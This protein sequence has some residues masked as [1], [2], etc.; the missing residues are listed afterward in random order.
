[1]FSP[2]QSLLPHALAALC[3]L[4]ILAPALSQ[5][6]T[7]NYKTPTFTL[8]YATQKPQIDGTIAEAEWR[9]ALGINA[10]QTSQ[11]TLSPR[12]AQWWLSWDEDNLYLA[13]RSPL[14]AGERLIQAQRRRDKDY[15]VVFDD[16]YEI[17]LDAQTHSPDGQP[18]FFQFLS[19]FAGARWDVMHEPAVGNFRMGWSSDWQ[20]RSR[21]NARN[22]WEMEVAIPR[23]SIYHDAPFRDGEVLRGLLARNFKRPWEQNTVEGAG[24]FAV[25]DTYSQ[26]RL[27]KS[28]PAL[29][30]LGVGDSDAQTVG[31]KLDAY[32]PGTAAP[33]R[34][35]FQS[36][37]GVKREGI[38]TPGETVNEL[39]LDKAGEAGNFRIRVMQGQTTL[40]DWA[41][42]RKFGDLQIPKQT[43]DDRGDTVKLLLSLNPIRDYVRVSGDFIDYDAR[44]QIATNRV[45][46]KDAQGV[47]LA[48]QDLPLDKLSYVSG[49]LKLPTLAPGQYS[50]TLTALGADGK[51][52]LTREQK[53]EKKDPRSF[54]WWNTPDGNIERVL[55]PWTP[56]KF[57][58]D[59]FDVWGR[60]MRAGHAGLPS[61]VVTQMN[62]LLA[63]PIHLVAQTADGQTLVSRPAP[64][65]A[66]SLRD[67]RAVAQAQ[68][69]LGEIQITTRVTVEFDGMYKVEMK[70]DP[71]AAVK[72]RSLRLVVPLKNASA[73]YL[74][75][76]GEGI[77]SGY[78]YG[79][80]P[81]EKQGRLWDS[82]QV[83]SQPMA[84]GS[85]IP[86]VWIG[87]PKGGLAW[88]ANSDQGW[89][90]NDQTPALEVRRDTPQST[91]LMLNLV[92][93]DFTLDAPRTVTFAFQA[94]PVKPMHEGWRMDSWWTGDTFRDY[95]QVEPKGGNL[96]FSSIPFTL[97]ADKSRAMVEAQ[98]AGNTA[99]LLGVDK[100]RGNA[101]PYFEHIRIGEKFVPEM[102]YF[103]DEWKTDV[104]EGLFY[105]KSY[106]DYMIYN[107]ARW[108]EQTGIDGFYVDNMHPLAD[109]N[110]EAGR[111]YVLPNGKV[112]PEYA[113]FETRDYFLRLRAVFA[114]HGKR[115]KIVLHM[116][117]NMIVPWVGAADIALDGEDNVIYPQMNK[118]FM[119][120]WSLERLR[121]DYPAQW[122][123]AVNFLQE[124]QGNWEGARLAKAMRAYSGSLILHDVLASANANGLNTP[125]WIGR[126][127]FGIENPDTKF[128][129]YWEENKGFDSATPDV[130]VSGWKRP[131]K[132]LLAVVNRGEKAEA[133]VTLDAAK[134]GL[135]AN[136]KVTDAEAGTSIDQTFAHL[137]LEKQPGLWQGAGQ[138]S[139]RRE[140]NALIVP[141]ERHDYRQV[142]I[143]SK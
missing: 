11:K 5:S 122:G 71:R 10:L 139:I 30:L 118:D 110:L 43:F 136:W 89:V 37:S 109:A 33:L 143:E 97:D 63:R 53:F 12:P 27:S 87:N 67:F 120:F 91:D 29:H 59:R 95:A 116:T 141:V 69:S 51:A 41:A 77:R 3:L 117:N 125:L 86:Y 104:S 42:Q 1:M 103:G 38:L 85:F 80:L 21:V 79:F 113:I 107:L 19:N 58:D 72:L 134:L 133:K 31:L 94:T 129:G 106:Q 49:T 127:R 48:K 14:R 47:T 75:A 25:R 7:D 121:V 35:V 99:F 54:A 101:V 108:I 93:D 32:A 56:V 102:E 92:S 46:I 60:G 52:V 114:E 126:D 44:A 115:D 6:V 105:G 23:A 13:M 130:Y 137:N 20:P 4:G 40:L 61:Q 8:P 119:D 128:I 84:V 64:L 62:T 50:A 135:P 100:Y 123:V 9:G 78:Y 24:S 76:C 98:H 142:I 140:G 138:A 131:G 74:H 88:F 28:A 90:P 15:N 57:A 124:Y 34:W 22:E 16:S 132:V 70:L 81:K 39:G 73:H 65:K 96:I 68:S 2:L 55:S 18:V 36:D 82:T 112:Q 17:Y 111:G 26:W 66:V 45:E 83:T